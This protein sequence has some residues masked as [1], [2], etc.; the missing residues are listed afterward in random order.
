MRV[1]HASVPAPV[2]LFP[3]LPILVPVSPVPTQLGSASGGGLETRPTVSGYAVLTIV[4]ANYWS[5]S[6]CIRPPIVHYCP[7]GLMP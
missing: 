5:F 1:G 3:G 7:R 4:V 2:S 6:T